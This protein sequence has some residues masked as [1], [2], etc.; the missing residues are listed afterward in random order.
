MKIN[1]LR[2]GVTIATIVI[3]TLPKMLMIDM[4]FLK[5]R[6]KGLEVPET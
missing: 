4:I 2:K 5:T 1:H 3:E 6:M